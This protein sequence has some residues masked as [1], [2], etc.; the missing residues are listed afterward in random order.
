VRE[1]G[2]GEEESE[3]GK[4]NEGRERRRVKGGRNEG[5]VGDAILHY[6]SHAFLWSGSLHI[7]CWSQ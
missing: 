5:R 3:G 4:R 6:F 7:R 2:E 1:G